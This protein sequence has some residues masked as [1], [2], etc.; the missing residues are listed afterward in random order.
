[1]KR[2]SCLTVRIW[3]VVFYQTSRDQPRRGTIGIPDYLASLTPRALHELIDTLPHNAGALGGLG[4]GVPLF[5]CHS[6]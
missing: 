5:S 3:R 2:S 1:M 6:P 4:N